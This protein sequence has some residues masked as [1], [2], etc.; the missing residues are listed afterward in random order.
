MLSSYYTNSSNIDTSAGI[1]NSLTSPN[2]IQSFIPTPNSSNDYQFLTDNNIPPSTLHNSITYYND[3]NS[4]LNY[5]NPISYTENNLYE[6][7]LNPK[8]DSCL[9]NNFYCESPK[10]KSK[11]FCAKSPTIKYTKTFEDENMEKTETLTR[12]IRYKNK[13]N[14]INSSPKSTLIYSKVSRSPQKCYYKKNNN[15]LLDP[16]TN[17]PTISTTVTTLPTKITAPTT[18]TTL[19]S[20]V[21]VCPPIELPPICAPTTETIINPFDTFGSIDTVYVP[22]TTTTIPVQT[23]NVPTVTPIQTTTVP[24]TVSPVLTTTVPT[25]TTPVVTTTVPTLQYVTPLPIVDNSFS[26]I[27]H[28]TSYHQNL[29][30]TNSNK[31][32]NKK[33]DNVKKFNSNTLNNS[34]LE[35][36]KN[37]EKNITDFNKINS[38]NSNN[39]SYSN[40][41]NNFKNRN[42]NKKRSSISVDQL[43]FGEN[44]PIKFNSSKKY[45]KYQKPYDYFSQYLFEKINE[46]RQNPKSYIPKIKEAIPKIYKDKR[47]ILVYKNNKVKVAL[48]KGKS[49]FEEA[50]IVL[51][52]MEPMEPLIFDPDITLE[53]PMNKNDFKNGKDLIKKVKEKL[54]EGKEI[55]AFWR[56]LIR[57][58]EICLLM[59][60]I[61]DNELDSSTG[62]KRKD[63]L[64]PKMKYIGINSGG[65]GK[66]FVC[67]MTFSDY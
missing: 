33:S 56:D 29:D 4:P 67:Y 21:Q 52:N 13:D 38:S 9:Y 20:T 22:P 31:L 53:I 10:R 35:E 58:P 1:Y 40:S 54:D 47:G 16:I 61:D 66:N 48:F 49:A 32:Q 50:I 51:E 63:I 7:T 24:T 62:S 64:S 8:I 28:P 57:D 42:S 34:N 14:Y 27:I 45:L 39:N 55:K 3:I 26:P 36:D 59:M 44:S 41:K 43:S 17:V 60:I 18:V 15:C 25:V 12:K 30:N 5:E 19:P 2:D 37:N 6:S 65:Y 11:K 46:I 23:T